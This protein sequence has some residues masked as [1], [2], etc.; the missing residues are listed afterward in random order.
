MSSKSPKLPASER[1][2][3]LVKT[4]L[5]DLTRSL[6]RRFFLLTAFLVIL[7]MR[8]VLPLMNSV[9]IRDSL[10][11]IAAL[12]APQFLRNGLFLMLSYTLHSVATAG[13]TYLRMF[14]SESAA[15]FCRRRFMKNALSIPFDEYE[16][17][18]KGDL[19][20]RITSDITESSHI[21]SYLYFIADEI[22]GPCVAIGFLIYISWK[23]TLVLFFVVG[24][25]MGLNTILARPLSAAGERYQGTLG[26]MSAYAIRIFE[27]L[28]VIKA[29]GAEGS[30]A[31]SFDVKVG[32]SREEA[33]KLARRTSWMVFVGM[34]GALALVVVFFGYGA[35]QAIAGHIS[36]GSMLA[37]LLLTDHITP[38]GYVGERWANMNKSAGIYRRVKELAESPKDTDLPF[39]ESFEQ[40]GLPTGTLTVRN[41]SYNYSSEVPVLKNV[42]FSVLPGQKV[43][44]VGRSGS[45][46]S[47]LMKILA[48]LYRPMPNTV[49]VN[50]FDM[51]YHRLEKGRDSLSYVPQEPFLFA[52]T[53][54]E[55]LALGFGDEDTSDPE[56]ELRIHRAL[57]SGSA[58]DFVTATDEGLLAPVG[59]RGTLLSGG[60]R[61]RLCLARGF[62]KGAPV[63]LLDEPTA[64]VDKETESRIVEK[65]LSQKD[66]TCLIVTHRLSVAEIVDSVL[67]MDE[68]TVAESGPHSKLM[69]TCGLYHAL[70]MGEPQGHNSSPRYSF[71]DNPGPKTVQEG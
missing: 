26:K 54:L 40:E 14:V 15:A 6:D 2:G 41:L 23:M 56:N 8:A 62:L 36:A 68:G 65:L 59:E 13:G 70:F 7:A 33:L 51:A 5:F 11:S 67:V 17:Y 1:P 32:E 10:D 64:S 60:Q 71:V 12:D 45:G 61:Q 42:S 31:R 52:G 38:L 27:G 35:Y 43:A 24:L 47:T 49:F 34:G 28:T 55:N 20:S 22:V 29:F 30:M 44:L 21:F 57:S 19:V 46:K 3:S 4:A 18:E 16:K 53:L 48:G 37:G 63:L 69:E 58:L 50:G 39:P 25:S 66:L 9:L